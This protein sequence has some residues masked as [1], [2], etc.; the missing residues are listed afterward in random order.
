LSKDWCSSNFQKTL[1][2]VLELLKEKG[3]VELIPGGTTSLVQPL[4]IMVNKP[5]K[6]HLRDLYDTRPR[7]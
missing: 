3:G 1:Y 7:D 6:D 5:F 2:E 4:D